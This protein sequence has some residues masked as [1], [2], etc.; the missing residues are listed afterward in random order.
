MLIAAIGL[1][2]FGVLCCCGT[3]A[4]LS[5]RV[6]LAKGMRADGLALDIETIDGGQ[7]S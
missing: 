3:P 5:S 7:V 6:S 4:M 1:V 2:I